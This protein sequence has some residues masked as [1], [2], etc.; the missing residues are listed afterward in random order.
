MV[1]GSEAWML[2]SSSLYPVQLA[3]HLLLSE[4]VKMTCT[5]LD[6]TN[7]VLRV[8]VEP[9]TLTLIALH[10]NS[11]SSANINLAGIVNGSD[12]FIAVTKAPGELSILAERRTAEAILHTVAVLELKLLDTPSRWKALK[13]V[14]PLDLT[15]VSDAKGR[16]KWR[17]RF[18][19]DCMVWNAGRSPP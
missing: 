6:L 16:K 18:D 19:T 4:S 7:P 1:L 10:P 15:L 12:G 13:I 5:T 11:I 17:M 8:Q 9:C 3:F 14:G 2:R